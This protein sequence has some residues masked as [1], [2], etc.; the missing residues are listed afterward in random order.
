MVKPAK[1]DSY[2]TFA[3][4][5]M[6]HMVVPT[7]VL[8]ATRKVMIWNHACE[9]LTGVMAKD[10]IG[11]QDHW[12]AFYDAPRYCLADV[13]ALDRSEELEAL[14]TTHTEPSETGSGLRAENWCTMPMAGHRL[15]LAIDAGPIYDDQG[16]LI[17]VV[18]TLRDMTEQKL[19]QEALQNLAARDGLTGIANRRAFD[20]RIQLE[21]LRA[22]REGLSLSLALIDVDF[23]KR[24]NDGYGHQQGDECLRQVASTIAS[25]LFRPGDLA[26]RYG[27]E[28]FAVIMPGTK[29]NGTHAVGERVC[30]RIRELALRH[31]FSD[32][33]PY[34][35]VSVGA[36][37]MIPEQDQS[38]AAL[39]AAAD[40][41][42]YAAKHSGRNRAMLAPHTPLR[43]EPATT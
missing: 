12:R 41:A 5:L 37:T 2:H 8:D 25:S 35:T 7:F 6:Q 3:V 24:Y 20:D 21:W 30:E 18:E 16:K 26:A 36:A 19:A 34:V 9:R 27:G 4:R 1:H 10:V 43:T 29:D 13:L 15:Y 23:F 32:V 14:Y 11:T 33:A 38:F 31:E 39:V 40:Q 22:Q 17:A 28:E 42:L